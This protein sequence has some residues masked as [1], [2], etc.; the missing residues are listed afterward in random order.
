M[1]FYSYLELSSGEEGD[2]RRSEG[3]CKDVSFGSDDDEVLV[4]VDMYG[5]PVL[6]WLQEPVGQDNWGNLPDVDE[7]DK[8]GNSIGNM[9]VGFHLLRL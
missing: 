4:N 3:S 7:G 8:H 5:I 1:D 6:G 9:I 2:S